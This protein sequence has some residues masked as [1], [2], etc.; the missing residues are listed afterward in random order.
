MAGCSRSAGRK[1]AGR[2]RLWAAV[3]AWL[4]L[5]LLA[6]LAACALRSAPVV[7]SSLT[8]EQAVYAH[9]PPGTPADVQQ[10]LVVVDVRYY[11]FDQELHQGQVVVHHA[12]AQDIRDV[13][14]VIRASR[15]P[16]ESVLPIAHPDLQHKAPY[17]LSPR[18]NNTSA[19]AW[20]PVVGAH[21]VSLHG[22]GLAIDIN[23]RQNPYIRGTLVIPPGAT[24]DPSRPGTLTPDSPVVLAFQRLGWE[25]GGDWAAQGKLDFMHFQKIPRELASWAASYRN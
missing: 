22:L 19:Y 11:G 18:T 7:D 3:R 20:R 12:L 13:F 14:E 8:R 5:A 17:G 24:Y 25:W 9:Q 15:F 10:Q 23:P 21:S 6:L 4:A 16:V 2:L 1:R